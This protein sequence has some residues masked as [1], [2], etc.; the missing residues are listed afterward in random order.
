[1]VGRIRLA[2]APATVKGARHNF[3]SGTNEPSLPNV[4][5]S[6][7]QARQ[8]SP[9]HRQAT[10]DPE[11]L[12]NRTVDWRIRSA[13]R[14]RVQLLATP[15]DSPNPAK[16][17]FTVFPGVASNAPAAL[18]PPELSGL[19]LRPHR[20][21]GGLGNPALPPC[22]GQRPPFAPLLSRVKL[23]NARN[24]FSIAGRI[25]EEASGVL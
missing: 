17:S 5:H 4:R 22:A 20:K 13:S 25:P 2:G 18:G 6:R 10:A 16:L 15:A 3:A 11:P 21:T 1:M 8:A 23:V 9:S 12:E 19:T 14:P 7:V 24:A